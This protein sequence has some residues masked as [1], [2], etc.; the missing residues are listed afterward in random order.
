MWIILWYPFYFLYLLPSPSNHSTS[1][2]ISNSTQRLQLKSSNLLSN[3]STCKHYYKIVASAPAK[4]SSQRETISSICGLRARIECE[5]FSEH[6][7]RSNRVTNRG[8]CLPL[9]ASVLLSANY[10]FLQ[11]HYSFFNFL[12]S[13]LI[14][15]LCSDISTGSSCYIHLCL[16]L[17]TAVWTL[18]NQLAM[19]IAYDLYFSLITAALAII[20]LCIKLCIHNVVINMFHNR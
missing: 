7:T 17:V 1:I 9:G 10:Y 5:P 13:S 2:I 14:P 15:E 8:Y 4:N 6:S 12:C 20:T 3:V 16:I 11:M 18:P 19:F